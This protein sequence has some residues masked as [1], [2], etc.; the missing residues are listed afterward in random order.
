MGISVYLIWTNL[1]FTNIDSPPQRYGGVD[2][3]LAFKAAKHLLNRIKTTQASSSTVNASPNTL[4]ERLRMETIILHATVLPVWR[5]RVSRT[6]AGPG[7]LADFLSLTVTC[8][9]AHSS[10]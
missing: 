8:L 9:T 4:L 5:Y 7:S 3:E 10:Q 1:C 2:L 6:G